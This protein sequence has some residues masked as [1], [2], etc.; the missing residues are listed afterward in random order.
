MALTLQGL[1][2]EG[3]WAQRPYYVRLVGYVDA[4]GGG[5]EKR[6]VLIRIGLGGPLI[7]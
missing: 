6:A 7:P 2:F 1:L 3:F 4:Q 5:Q